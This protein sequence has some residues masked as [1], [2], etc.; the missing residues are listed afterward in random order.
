MATLLWYFPNGGPGMDFA[1]WF[2]EAGIGDV[3]VPGDEGPS[4]VQ[5]QVLS[6]PDGGQGRL[7]FWR[8]KGGSERQ[9][10]VNSEKQTWYEAPPRDGLPRGR[11]WLGVWNDETLQPA[12]LLRRRPLDGE[13]VRLGKFEW[14][15]PTARTLPKVFRFG[16]NGERIWPYEYPEHVAYVD[17]AR[18]MVLQ[19]IADTKPDGF[20]YQLD[21]HLEFTERALRLNYRVTLEVLHLMGA[22]R[23]EDVWRTAHAASGAP[24]SAAD[25]KKNMVSM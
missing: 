22:I 18:A 9:V 23:E 4:V 6:G 19:L 17:A 20:T 11:F 14:I 12:D 13:L 16:D 7:C 10:V 21:P 24:Q 1:R 3:I 15:V 8:P 25:V 5:T 2:A